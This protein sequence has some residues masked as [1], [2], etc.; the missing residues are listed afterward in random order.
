MSSQIPLRL[1]NSRHIN[2]DLFIPGPN[3]EALE[4]LR[5][6]IKQTKDDFLY[7]WGSPGTGKTHILQALC[8][9]GAALQ[10]KTAYVPLSEMAQLRPEV[11]QG[12]E[13]LDCVCIDDVNLITD[14][15]KW[16]EELFNLFNRIRDN[17]KSLVVTSTLS[18]SGL[19]ITLQDLKSRLSSGVTYHLNY[20]DEKDR[21]SALKARAHSLG[22][23]LSD[24]VLDFIA[25]R[26]SR[27]MH[28]LF[29][30]LD[31]LDEAT[32]VSKKK[33]TVPFVKELMERHA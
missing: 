26:V 24:E 18:P 7:L 25:K 32:L 21:L 5:N 2:F 13:S 9:E 19:P 23:D 12:L 8:S 11:L 28:S 27:D 17:Q 6:F 14:N 22:F 3:I 20:L 10:V 1:G 33:L 30:W 15:T 4:Y 31:R 29:T 16:E